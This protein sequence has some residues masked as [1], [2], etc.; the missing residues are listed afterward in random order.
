MGRRGRLGAGVEALATSIRVT[1]T[2]NG[3]SLRGVAAQAGGNFGGH[4]KSA[5][6][7]I[8]SILMLP[9]W[10]PSPLHFLVSLSV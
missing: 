7:N 6:E 4:F 5:P 3:T 10:L 8:V 1:F 9:L 2:L